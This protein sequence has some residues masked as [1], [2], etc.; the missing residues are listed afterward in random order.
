MT[1]NDLLNEEIFG[2]TAIVYRNG[3]ENA[4]KNVL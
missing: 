4:K 3:G 2:N 1:I